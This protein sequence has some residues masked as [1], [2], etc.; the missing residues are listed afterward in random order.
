MRDRY[1][2]TGQ[3][4]ERAGVEP[5]TIRQWRSR[6]V[7]GQRLKGYRV[8]TEDG[9]RTVSLE[10]DVLKMERTARHAGGG[11]CQLRR[12]PSQ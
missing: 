8:R 10:L 11:S 1:L 2:T 7:G 4:A 6:G 3:A 5:A 9:I 12:G